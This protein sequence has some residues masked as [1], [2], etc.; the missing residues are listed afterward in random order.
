MCI[1]KALKK[2]F[3]IDKNQA[4][5]INLKND[6]I[7]FKNNYEKSISVKYRKNNREQYLNCCKSLN[8]DPIDENDFEVA[9]KYKKQQEEMAQELNDEMNRL[10]K[11]SIKN[12]ENN[13]S[14]D[15]H[16]M[17]YDKYKQAC[18][19]QGIKPMRLDELTN[20]KDTY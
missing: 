11:R 13:D 12:F 15:F 9:K 8:E 18:K 19:N 6:Y 20:S 7:E 5:Y 1:S 4:I 14:Y 2:Q 17:F 10:E 16:L 3:D